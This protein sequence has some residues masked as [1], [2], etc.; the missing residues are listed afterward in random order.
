MTI[1]VRTA[2]AMALVCM[3][4]AAKGDFA[5]AFQPFKAALGRYCPA[6]H[7]DLLTPASLNGNIESFLQSLPDADHQR[8]DRSDEVKGACV[9]SEA[10]VSCQNIGYIEAAARLRL[11]DALA[12][13]V[14]RTPVT[15]EPGKV[16]N[17]P[18]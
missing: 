2:V 18:S 16:C 5:T 17:S 8:L 10:G 9:H 14:C 4:L 6:K 1:P 3:S 7:L 11:L 13:S 15:C 12:Q